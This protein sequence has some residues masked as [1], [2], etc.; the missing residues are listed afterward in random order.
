MAQALKGKENI[1]IMVTTTIMA[2]IMN[3][4]T[5]TIMFMLMNITITTIPKA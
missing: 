5:A 2:I 4:I 1:N 3:I